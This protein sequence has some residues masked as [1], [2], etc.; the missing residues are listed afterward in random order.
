MKSS[1]GER[2][3][4]VALKEKE[5]AEMLKQRIKKMAAKQMKAFVRALR[6]IME[7]KDGTGRANGRK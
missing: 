2:K 4:E 3:K 1:G 7:E 6:K 5:E